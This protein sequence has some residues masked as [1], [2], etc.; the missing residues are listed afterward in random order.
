MLIVFSGNIFIFNILGVIVFGNI[1]NDL[2]LWIEFLNKSKF[3]IYFVN[4]KKK[5]G[6]KFLMYSS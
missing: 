2:L 1:Y 6:R 5:I 4:M 3:L